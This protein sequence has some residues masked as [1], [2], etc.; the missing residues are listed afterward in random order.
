LSGGDVRGKGSRARGRE[1][2]RAR[3]RWW[4][5]GERLEGERAGKREGEKKMVTRGAISFKE[6]RKREMISTIHRWAI[7]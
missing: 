7:L 3:K 5:E 1:N 4:L 6:R 2:E